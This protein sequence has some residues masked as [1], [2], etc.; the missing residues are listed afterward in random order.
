MDLKLV[1]CAHFIEHHV[2]SKFARVWKRQN[3]RERAQSKSAFIAFVDKVVE[4][5]AA[6]PDVGALTQELVFDVV[7]LCV[8]Y[9]V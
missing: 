4:S 3:V 1:F 7:N 6:Y 9:L 2:L 8:P 5:A